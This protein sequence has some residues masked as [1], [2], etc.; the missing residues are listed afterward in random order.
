MASLQGETG[1]IEQALA[2]SKKA[3]DLLLSVRRDSAVMKGNEPLLLKKEL[4]SIYNNLG[5]WLQLGGKLAEAEDVYRKGL[6]MEAAAPGRGGRRPGHPGIDRSEPGHA[7][8]TAPRDPDVTTGP[9]SQFKQAIA[10]LERLVADFPRVPR[11][12]IHLARIYDVLSTLYWGTDRI[13]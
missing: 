4:A 12:K 11:Y 2:E 13:G 5:K 8:R 9:R 6:A 10:S 3:L 1:R 7:G